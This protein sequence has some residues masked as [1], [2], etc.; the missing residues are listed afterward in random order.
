MVSLSSSV[1]NADRIVSERAAKASSLTPRYRELAETLMEGIHSG[2][3]AVGDR[4]PGEIVLTQQFDVSRHTVREAL[5]VLED[6][7]LIK[8]QRGVGTV[9]QARDVGPS[10]VQAVREPNELMKYPRNSRLKVV[11]SKP[12]R[13][14]RATARKTGC[15]T[16]SCWQRITAVRLPLGQG[17]PLCFVDIYVLPEYAGIVEAVPRSSEPVYELLAG[18]YQLEIDRVELKISASLVSAQAAPLLQAAEG[19]P[20]LELVRRYRSGGR[21]FEVS[22]S[23]HPAD[24]FNYTL[25]FQRGWRSGGGWNWS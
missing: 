14:N 4:L 7:G 19:A 16:G 6:L 22:V 13:L 3:F 21:V 1:S 17:L 11:E 24:R 8:R 9:V 20:T 18:M 12:V 2:R 15:P 10:Y 25:E 23:E 5:R